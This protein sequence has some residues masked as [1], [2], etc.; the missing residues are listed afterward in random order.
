MINNNNITIIQIIY[1]KF[2]LIHIY[3]YKNIYYKL[4][5]NSTSIYI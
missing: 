1:D 2:I 4:I 3:F 5:I